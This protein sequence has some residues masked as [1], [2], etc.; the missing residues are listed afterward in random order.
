M[1]ITRAFCGSCVRK[2]SIFTNACFLDEPPFHR[3]TLRPFK[4]VPFFEKSLLFSN[5]NFSLLSRN[6]DIKNL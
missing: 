2:K 1:C 3:A 5:L 6:D 4:S